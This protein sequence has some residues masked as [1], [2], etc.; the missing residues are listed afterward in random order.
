MRE[1]KTGDFVVLAWG[2]FLGGYA[3]LY[4]T[5][6]ALK[7]GAW[8]ITA[9]EH[10]VREWVGALS[11]W[12]AAFA[13]ALT[14][15]YLAKQASDMSR[16]TAAVVRDL[17]PVLSFYDP[18]EVNIRDAF[19]NRLQIVN[20]NARPILI[21]AISVIAPTTL[22]GWDFS[23][24]DH[25]AVRRQSLERELRSGRMYVPGI[26]ERE[27]QRPTVVEIDVS[28]EMNEASLPPQ[29]GED[30]NFIHR[31]QVALR[32]DIVIVGD[33][34]QPISLTVERPDAMVIAV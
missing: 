1:M 25:D 30:A 21:K 9:E 32:V 34:H 8:C 3:F 28:F 24:V 6:F 20:I 11:G 23:V 22:T 29:K 2:G 19:A 10:C 13:A 15:G 14:I 12:A 27:D 18:R 26:A 4:G 31:C 5:D 7:N 17:P 33:T 16:Q